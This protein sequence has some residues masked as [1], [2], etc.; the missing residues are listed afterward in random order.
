[1][2]LEGHGRQEGGLVQRPGAL[3]VFQRHSEKCWV[4]SS[5]LGTVNH[6]SFKGINAFKSNQEDI[7]DETWEP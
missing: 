2:Q 5:N 3:E 7:A 6:N 4:N 1:M